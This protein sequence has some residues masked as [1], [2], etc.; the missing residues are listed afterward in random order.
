MAD[1]RQVS[2]LPFHVIPQTARDP[3][4]AADR[5]NSGRGAEQVREIAGDR[6]VGDGHT[7]LD[8]AADGIGK[9]A[10]GSVQNGSWGV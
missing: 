5:V 9:Q 7:E 4:L 10:S 3:A 8:G 2:Y 1:D 6:G